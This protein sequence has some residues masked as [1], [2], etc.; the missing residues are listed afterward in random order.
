[1]LFTVL[2]LTLSLAAGATA[3]IASSSY[4]NSAIVS[5]DAGETWIVDRTTRVD[6]LKIADGAVITA[7]EG[8]SLT[9]T[10]NGI[11]TPIEP[12]T[13]IGNIVLTPT[14]NI[15]VQYRELDP[16][17][18]KTG[19]YIENGKYV[20]EK[21]VAAVVSE[22]KVV[23]KSIKDVKITSNEEK[24]NGIIVTG[25]SKFNILNPQVYL[26]GNGG[27]DFAGYG[28][29]IMT[30]GNADVTVDGATII[31]EGCIR[32]AIFVGDNSVL[33]VNNSHIE[34]RN[35][36]LPEDYSF[37]IEMGKMME[38]PWMLGIKGN[39]RTTNLVG[40]GTVYYNNCYIK[41]EAWGALSTDDTNTV[42]MYVTDSLIETVKSGYGAY[43]IGDS[44]DTFTR[45]TM[46]VADYGLIMANGSGSGVFDASVVNSGKIGVMMHG[47]NEGNL[48]IN[49]GSVFNTK[50]AVIQVKSSYPTIVVDNAELNSESGIILQAVENDDPFMAMMMAGGGPGGPPAG[51]AA[52]PADTGSQEPKTINATFKNVTLNGDFMN[53]MT[54]LGGL[55][56]TFE[57]A[58]VKGAITTATVEHATG[59]NGEPVT[60]DHPELYY[61]I[62]EFIPTYCATEDPYGVNATFA[63]GSQWI[64]DKTSY[65]TGLTIAKGA[66][67]TAPEG[68]SLT[69]TVNGVERPIIP[70]TYSGRIVLAVN[71]E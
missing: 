12:G 16:H 42:R 54:A 65:L 20:P 64:V 61:L 46:N 10:V 11:G 19:I 6:V 15:I 36:T 50:K 34:S 62:G 56:L 13:Y 70:G 26:T 63:R 25:N 29:G 67:V 66:S 24:F 14:E 44:I 18:L 2:L 52:P 57:N 37:T 41:S 58:V 33:R 43:S 40:N 69:M 47:G 8:Y 71:P 3:G 7:P 5:V 48:L 60:M 38:C 22:G 23:G 1:M 9:M 4:K 68:Y 49:N 39:C 45:S 27:N 28:A 53:A 59:P 55:N 30:G 35:G 21:S 51:D 31:N 17:Y 32:P